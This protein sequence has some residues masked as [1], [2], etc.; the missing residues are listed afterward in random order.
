MTSQ[1]TILLESQTPTGK[2]IA[3]QLIVQMQDVF[4]VNEAVTVLSDYHHYKPN[5]KRVIQARFFDH[6]GEA[7]G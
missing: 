6:S 3:Q 1:V 5:G 2:R 4:D 7:N